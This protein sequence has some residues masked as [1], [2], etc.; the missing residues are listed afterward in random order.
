[1]GAHLRI[2]VCAQLRERGLQCDEQRAQ[3]LLVRR[4]EQRL[5]P[6][7]ERERRARAER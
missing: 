7:Q 4:A 6:L 1:V 5:G 3:R 2:G